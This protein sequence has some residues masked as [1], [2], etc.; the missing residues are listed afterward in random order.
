MWP[1]L[2]TFFLLP[3]ENVSRLW[4]FMDNHW[5]Y[6]RIR[7]CILVL[8]VIYP[9]SCQMKS[10]SPFLAYRLQSSPIIT[11]K[12]LTSRCMTPSGPALFLGHTGNLETAS[13]VLS[14]PRGSAQK[15]GHRVPLWGLLHLIFIRL[16]MFL[17]LPTFTSLSSAKNSGLCSS[18][19]ESLFKTLAPTHSGQIQS[20]QCS[21]KG[22]RLLETKAKED[23]YLFF[24]PWHFLPL[25]NEHRMTLLLKNREDCINKRAIKRWK[26]LK[27]T[28]AF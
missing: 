6:G 12:P 21:P 10:P 11:D 1:Q 8:A 20:S 2:I 14:A 18:E 4:V 22:F 7:T 23:S 3:A 27:Y 16:T 13:H 24:L 28:L 17:L 15:A 26:K 9:H 25:V 5:G 19:G